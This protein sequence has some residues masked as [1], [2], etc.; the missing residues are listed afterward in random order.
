MLTVCPQC[1][2]VNR[3]PEQKPA[4]EGKCGRCKGALFQGQ[5]VELTA[6]SFEKHVARGELPVL[7]DFWAEWCGPCKMMAP[8]L[9]QAAKRLEPRLRIAKLET[10]RQPEI[11]GRF[12]IRSIPTLILFRQGREQARVSGALNLGQLLA[13]VEQHL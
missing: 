1:Q 2:S 7:V 4:L 3:L 5:P 10:D 12:G 8:V 11:S 6:E 9:E 13:W